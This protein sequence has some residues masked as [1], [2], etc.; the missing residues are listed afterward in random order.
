MLGIV[1]GTTMVVEGEGSMKIKTCDGQY[2]QLDGVLYAPKARHTL[3]SST[4]LAKDG[5]TVTHK[6]GTA[7][8]TDSHGQHVLKA[9]VRGGLPVVDTEICEGNAAVGNEVV[10]DDYKA[11]LAHYRLGHPGKDRQFGATG[12]KI[13]DDCEICVQAKMARAP[14]P[15]EVKEDSPSK[16]KE[17]LEI[18]S[19]DL[20]GPLDPDLHGRRYVMVIND[21]YTRA[22]W[23][24]PL[25][26]KSDALGMFKVFHKQAITNIGKLVKRVHTD[27]EVIFNNKEMDKFCC[28]NGINKTYTVPYTPGQ[29]GITERFNRTLFT[30]ARAMRL[31]A[32]LPLKYWAYTLEAASH[33]INRLPTA[34]LKG[35]SPYEL[36]YGT[37]PDLDHLRVF[38]CDVYVH[39]KHGKLDARAVKGKFLGYD[40]IRK[41][42]LVLLPNGKI[43]TE[44]DVHFF[45][46]SVVDKGETVNPELS[47]V[48]QRS[49]GANDDSD[50]EDKAEDIDSDHDDDDNDDGGDD[51][52]QQ[53][54]Q[55]QQ[56]QHEQEQEQPPAPAEQQ[57]PRR[58]ARVAQ[59]SLR[60]LESV[61]NAN[62]A[63]T[64]N[65]AIGDPQWMKAMEDEMRA[66]DKNGTWTVVDKERGVHAL[67]TKWVLRKKD[68]GRYKA[69]LVARGD[70]QYDYEF[71]ETYAP[72]ARETTIKI[73]MAVTASL[74]FKWEQLD[75]KTAYLNGK[76]DED[77]YL[78]PPKGFENQFKDKILKLNKAIYG[79]KQAG[80]KWNET[81][82]SYLISI[83]FKQSDNDPCLF[84]SIDEN[85]K[86]QGMIVLYVDDIL[87]SCKTQGQLE[88]VR[89]KLTKRF[90]MNLLGAPKAYLGMD[91][92]RDKDG[93][94]L[95]Q[96]T[97]IDKLLRRFSMENAKPQ[98]TPSAKRPEPRP[99]HEQQ[100]S[101]KEMREAIGALL[102]LSRIARPD[103]ACIISQLARFQTDPGPEH[104]SAIKR[105]LRYLK[106]TKD[107][108]L[109]FPAKQELRLHGYSDSDY[110]GD[111]A[112][113]RSTGGFVFFLNNTP[114]SWRS[115][116]QASVAISS[117]ESE[118]VALSDA[119][120]EALY[121]RALLNEFKIS[122]N[123][124]TIIY[125]DNQAAIAIANR[126]Q[127]HG[128][129]KHLGVRTKFIREQ[130]QERQVKVIYCDTNNMIA[131]IMTKPLARP[132]FQRLV[133]QLLH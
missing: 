129:L 66:H 16:A 67:P 27:N 18:I 85:G 8:V 108:Y 29:N 21:N 60:L 132:T 47:P 72:V 69:R 23:V 35:K 54:Q 28:D 39:D 75:V 103:I 5:Y 46:K 26:N 87:L 55:Q 96:V 10:T 14:V 97:Y 81:I 37:K 120:Q 117:T 58:S 61:A 122:V 4:K 123:E 110:A 19:M 33:V 62:S 30:T 113:R 128:R 95:S 88:D 114:I 45:E 70:L 73:L 7:V 83:G 118:Y 57:G 109:F 68:D 48:L 112:T 126:A 2:V 34:A 84:L 86:L 124:P 50:D 13:V 44:R 49:A 20:A 98:P 104:L 100:V 12:T 80:L 56:E 115:K 119:T 22:N 121:L 41:G 79:L 78:Q 25:K 42:Y 74:N 1:G 127:Y 105:V 15:K 92:V 91:I 102:Y 65:D 11:R 63:I 125:E 24:Y 6:G 3:I 38:G 116:L 89:N 17:P 93:I 32:G 52:P 99:E 53:P 101:I 94:K 111:T 64:L 71:D 82:T 51:Q 76:V 131:D 40:K 106:G 90:D 133:K 31:A 43:V 107:Y 77:I 59:P 36:W 9:T 130:V